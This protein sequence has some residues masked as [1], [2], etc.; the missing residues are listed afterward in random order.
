[1][2]DRKTLDDLLSIPWDDRLIESD[3]ANLGAW[4]KAHDTPVML[5]EFGT[6]GFCADPQS[7]ATWT[8]SVRRAAETAGAGWTYWE[9]DQGFGFFPDRTSTSGFDDGMIEALLT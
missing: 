9:A 4:S 1:M 6:L 8:R 5:G 7:R 3:F 2:S